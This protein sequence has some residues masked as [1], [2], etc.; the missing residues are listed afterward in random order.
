MEIIVMDILDLEP[1]T[2]V[3]IYDSLENEDVWN[4]SWIIIM[5][6]NSTGSSSYLCSV[7]W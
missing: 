7:L 4:D 5:G 1:E 3:S 6:S 2:V